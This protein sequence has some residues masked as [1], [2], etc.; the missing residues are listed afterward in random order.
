LDRR[1]RPVIPRHVDLG[2]DP[3]AGVLWQF[4]GG[5]EVVDRRCGLSG[6]GQPFSPFP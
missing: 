5:E 4:P 1:C 2:G 6:D 3:E